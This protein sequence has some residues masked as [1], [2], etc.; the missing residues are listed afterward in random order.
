MSIK[1]FEPLT[2]INSLLITPSPKRDRG[3]G[4]ETWP[5]IE[6]SRRGDVIPNL[7]ALGNPRTLGRGGGQLPLHLHTPQLY[8]HYHCTV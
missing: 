1:Y 7:P 4:P 2:M 3:N 6:P 5:G 8:L